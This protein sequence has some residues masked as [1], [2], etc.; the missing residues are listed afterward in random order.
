MKRSLVVLL[1][2][3]SLGG[4]VSGSAQASPLT[5][6]VGYWSFEE[7]SGTTTA[8]LSSTSPNIPLTLGGGTLPAW[9]TAGGPWGG[10]FGNH[11]SFSGA[12]YL[13]TG[14]DQNALD[15]NP[16]DPFSVAGWVNLDPGTSN[17]WL[18]SKM[19]SS[20]AFRG[21]GVQARGSAAASPQNLVEFWLRDT[22]SPTNYLAIRTPVGILPES[23]WMHVGATYDGTAGP[24]GVALYI[25]GVPVATTVRSNTLIGTNTSNSVPMNVAGRN[26]A[27][28]LSGG[29]DEFGVWNRVLSPQEMAALA[30]PHP[31]MAG[32]VMDD[33]NYTADH[34]APLAGRN[35]GLGWAGPWGDGTVGTAT[36]VV[37]VDTENN[38][39]H[40]AYPVESY[41]T[42][43]VYGTFSAWREVNRPVAE[44]MTGEVW[45]SFLAETSESAHRAGIS[46][47]NDTALEFNSDGDRFNIGLFGDQLR[48]AAPG[49]SPTTASSGLGL[50]ETHLV[51]GRLDV[52]SGDDALSLWLN[53]DFTGVS[54]PTDMPGT[55]FTYG[56]QDF[57]EELSRIGVFAYGGSAPYGQVDGLR[58]ATG[59]M[60]FLNVT[61]VPE[62][63]TAVLLACAFVAFLGLRGRRLR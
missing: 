1:V 20:G 37:L 54:G 13:T 30:M 45:F 58:F 22:N 47:N 51:V 56:G 3:G 28:S 33:F 61:G 16:A 29:V 9:Q 63:S 26:N 42:G 46:I 39:N 41:G 12:N 5:D 8:D 60:A 38:L 6:A 50:G 59:P 27:G 62:P 43:L 53:P 15:F 57:I 23:E 31:T 4:L 2:A 35:G 7:G 10:S 40:A 44:P 48:V 24:G 19:E 34:Q 36:G 11:L 25:N 17:V 21:W 49:L 18:A 55:T 32:L 52:A 14:G